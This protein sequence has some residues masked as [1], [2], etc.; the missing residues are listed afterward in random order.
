MGS[1]I[2]KHICNKMQMRPRTLLNLVDITD[3]LIKDD[4]VLIQLRQDCESCK[5]Q[6]LEPKLKKALQ[7]V[8]LG[9]NS[10]LLTQPQCTFC[11]GKIPIPILKITH[12]GFSRTFRKDRVARHKMSEE[13][14]LSAEQI[15]KK[16]HSII[17]TTRMKYKAIDVATF[18]DNHPGLFW[19]IIFYMS[20]YG[21]PYD[22]I[23]P[24]QDNSELENIESQF[25]IINKHCIVKFNP[26]SNVAKIINQNARARKQTH[27]DL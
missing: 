27:C 19:N 23:L 11:G 21:L 12:G 18:R 9:A 7:S 4:S 2:Y 25:D 6:L 17:F 1:P 24:Y 26:E 16:V 3:K 10:E 22:M 13:Y 15:Y 5:A 14:F 8:K 20:N